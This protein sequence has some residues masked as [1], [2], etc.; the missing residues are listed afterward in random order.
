MRV[1]I[2]VAVLAVG[3][4]FFFGIYWPKH[5]HQVALD[6]AAAVVR[7]YRSNVVA[8]EADL[9]A[10]VKTLASLELHPASQPLASTPYAIVRT[11]VV[12]ERAGLPAAREPSLYGAV[13]LD[14]AMSLVETGKRYA[15][16]TEPNSDVEMAETMLAPVANMRYAVL[17]ETT[18]FAEPAMQRDRTLFTPGQWSAR[19]YFFDVPARQYIAGWTIAV[20]SSSSVR[21]GGVFQGGVAL[22]ADLLNSIKTQL[23]RSVEQHVF[24]VR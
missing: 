19:A 12:R 9:E 15:Y 17:V 14:Q 7:K 8:R 3:A 2:A 23:A 16:D 21:Q 10:I 4:F 22:D 11:G 18:S 1:V 20:D 13:Y 5:Q 6:D 24:G